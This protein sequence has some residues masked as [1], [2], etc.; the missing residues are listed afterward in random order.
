MA[1]IDLLTADVVLDRNVET[2]DP[3]TYVRQSGWAP[4]GTYPGRVSRQEVVPGEPDD[5]VTARLI[6]DADAPGDTLRDGDRV[7]VDGT[8]WRVVAGASPARDLDGLHHWRVP[9]RREAG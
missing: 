6:L 1:L 7:T 2:V 8:R 3:D 4:I 5:V 9:I